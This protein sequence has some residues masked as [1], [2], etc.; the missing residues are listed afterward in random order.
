MKP[1]GVRGEVVVDLW[2]E[3]LERLRAGSVLVGR[4]PG[5]EPQ[6]AGSGLAGSERR[7]VVEASRRDRH[8]WLVVFEGVAERD[9]AEA[10][11]GVVLGA[12]PLVVPGELWVH[13]LMGAEVVDVEGRVLGIVEAVERN[14][15]SD[16]LV[17][18]TGTLVPLR[19]V[20][21][22]EPGT[23]VTVEVPE[24]LA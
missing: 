15:A 13:E 19:F 1:H 11:R 21:G 16:L 24:G 4:Q 9:T 22:H 7:L 12:P 17:L 20:V 14:P 8:R 18:S 2:T 3:N 6:S 5:S 10:L 23:Q